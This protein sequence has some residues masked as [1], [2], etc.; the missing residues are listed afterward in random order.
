MAVNKKIPKPKEYK[1]FLNFT[2][3]VQVLGFGTHN[4]ISQLVKNGKL[5]AY[6]LPLTQKLRVLKQ[7]VESLVTTEQN[8]QN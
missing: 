6:K 4:R 2:D 3:A 1:K 7:D 8:D 5:Q